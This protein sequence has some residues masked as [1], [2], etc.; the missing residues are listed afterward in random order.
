MGLINN[1]IPFGLILWGQTHIASGLASILN[2]TTPLFTVLLAHV[3][4]RDERLN[5]S[6]LV[7]VAAGLFGVAVMIGI[8]ALQ[9]F[10]HHLM[11]EIAV[12]GAA[13]SYGLATI[14]G[15][16]L[17]RAAAACDRDLSGHRFGADGAAA[18]SRHRPAVDACSARRDHM[19][20]A[21]RAFAHLNGARLSDVFPH[22][23]GVRGQQRRAGNFLVPVFA[24][25]L[26]VGILGEVLA[27]RHIAGMVLIG[28]GLAAIDGR[29]TRWCRRRIGGRRQK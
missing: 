3:L 19:G 24:V 5:G 28:P 10:G 23:E 9:D 16:A 13:F 12:L 26:G 21:D 14:W 15:P 20:R 2:A 4:T 27:W 17:P 22:F 8:E 7:G 29:L 18:L 11:G 25:A 1:L 6:K